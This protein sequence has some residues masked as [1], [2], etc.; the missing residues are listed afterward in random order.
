MKKYVRPGFLAAILIV[1]TVAIYDAAVS[2][3]TLTGVSDGI[4]YE[5]MVYIIDNNGDT[6]HLFA[7]SRDGEQK[8]RIDL[9][10]LTGTWWNAYSSLSVDKDGCVYVYSYGRTMDTDERRSIVYRCDFQRGKLEP[11]WEI[12]GGKLNHIQVIDGAVYYTKAAGEKQSGIYRQQGGTSPQISPQEERLLLLNAE[13]SNIKACAYETSSGMIWADGNGRFYQNNNVLMPN[14]ASDYVNICAGKTGIVYTDLWRGTINQMDSTGQRTL[15]FPVADMEYLHSQV[16]YEDILPFHYEPDGTWSAG[17]DI[18]PGH[19]VLGIF[20]E[21]GRQ[22]S[23][24]SQITKS[25][26]ARALQSFWVIGLCLAAGFAA[27]NIIRSVLRWTKGTVPITVQLLGVL[28]P[29]IVLGL[30]FLNQK[31][32]E[33]MQQRLLRMDYDLLYSMADQRLSIIDPEELKKMD[34]TQ[35]PEDKR[36]QKI[37]QSKDYSTLNKDIY[38]GGSTVREPVIAS[39]YYWLMLMKEE[40]L[41][42]AQV[43]GMHYFNG[44]VAYDRGWQEI[45]K[46]EQAM[47]LQQIV[48]TEYNDFS[49]DFVALYVPVIDEEGTA[50][51]VMECG[52]NRRILTYEVARQMEQIHKLLLGLMGV[53]I[54]VLTLVLWF[55]LYPL[56]RVRAAVE[57]VSRGKLGKQVKVR[58]RDEV[59]EIAEAFNHMSLRL[60]EQVEYIQA[61]SDGYASFVP[62]KVFEILGRDDITQIEL[63]DQKEISAAV[64]SVS[65]VEFRGMAKS[66]NG[67]MLYRM[68]N[69]MLQVMIPIVA[70]DAGVIDHMGEDGFT[71]YYPGGSREA[72]S[73]AISI[74]EK[75]YWMRQ[76]GE[77]APVYRCVVHYGRVR[78]G[79]VGQMERMEAS[80]ISE[81]MT[82]SGFLKELGEKYG[83]GILV[84]QSAAAEIPDFKERFHARMLGCIHIRMTDS[85]EMI[86]DVY[87]GDEAVE[88]RL[89]G[90]TAELFAGAVKAYL[91]EKYYEARLEFAKILRINPRDLASR[92]YVYRC[93]RYYQSKDDGKLR[94]YLEEY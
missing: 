67:E 21:Q 61:C 4:C 91:A 59:A 45:E 14:R 74:R 23:Q 17:V 27:Y 26:G 76:Q 94:A 51:G 2:S 83:A 86:Y 82:F 89:K 3:Y 56:V 42:Y 11:V 90:E 87:D 62:Q 8:G 33:S 7:A 68:I 6:Y 1:M 41:R 37:F 55:F 70:K 93:D 10:K 52:L 72:L 92:E 66:M 63:G 18:E 9:P 28:V 39:V 60:K 57:E 35:I 32:E 81:V 53:L 47:A 64:L 22:I 12:P 24:I 43:D 16:D 34:L 46:M 77:A 29:V 58:G 85:L 54:L 65:S 50:I 30:V 73:G 84:T 40:V 75:L 5:D 13:F 69:R 71:A 79:I 31:L 15:L 25:A 20:D 88:R 19:R 48:K 38:A 44:R 80:T 78:V 36:Y 49:G